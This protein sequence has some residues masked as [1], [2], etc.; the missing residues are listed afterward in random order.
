MSFVVKNKGLWR[1]FV[2]IL[3]LLSMLGPWAFDQLN[4]PAQ[5]PCAPPSIRLQGDFCGYPRSG[6]KTLLWFAGG[7]FNL[8]D[9]LVRGN[10]VMRP[11]EFITLVSWWIIVLP[12]FSMLL[13]LW[14]TNSRRLQ[15][16][17]LIAWSIASFPALALFLLQT[18]SDQF[19]Q[20]AYGLWGIW[21]Y[22][23]VA[24]VTTIFEI[25]ESR[26]YTRLS[27]GI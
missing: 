9:G 21:L 11:P 12:F 22:I 8:L 1:K 2:L 5:Y 24:I 19:V 27:T 17:N 14:N 23:L 20:L 25:L 16:I 6:F 15:T 18:N 7:L 3:F 26:S 10:F 13:L 4:V